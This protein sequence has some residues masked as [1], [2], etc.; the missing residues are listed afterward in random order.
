MLYEYPIYDKYNKIKCY[1]II[2]KNDIEKV[3]KYT[4]RLQGRG[5]IKAKINNKDIY[6]HRYLMDE[7][8]P[9]IIIDHKN[10]NP[11]DNRKRNL[12]RVTIRQNAFNRTKPRGSSSKYKGVSFNKTAKKWVC[13]IKKDGIKISLGTFDTEEDAAKVYN[14]NAKQMFGKYS[15]LNVI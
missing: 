12:R 14:K 11:L 5:Y 9:K 2:D 7:W 15:K 6:L 4:F 13:Y 1:T 8:D 10:N 3:N